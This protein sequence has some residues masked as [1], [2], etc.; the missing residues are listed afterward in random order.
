VST[1]GAELK[2]LAARE[3]SPYQTDGERA[4]IEGPPIVLNPTVAQAL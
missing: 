3:L 4:L 2:Q 1:A